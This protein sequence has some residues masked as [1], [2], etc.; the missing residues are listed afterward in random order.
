MEILMARSPG[1]AVFIS[2][3]QKGAK[4]KEP[5]SGP[6]AAPIEQSMC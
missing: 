1:S 4:R 5:E 3:T 6:P 2:G